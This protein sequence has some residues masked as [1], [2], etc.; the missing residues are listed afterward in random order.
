MASQTESPQANGCSWEKV[1]RE[2]HSR[3]LAQQQAWGDVDD[4]DLGRYLA[5][6]LSSAETSHLEDQLDA[7]PELR[8]LTD[9]VRDVLDGVG[10]VESAEEPAPVLRFE[11]PARNRH[12]VLTFLRRRASVLAAACL[13]IILGTAMPQAGYFSA[14]HSAS[15]GMASADLADRNGFFAQN[16]AMPEAEGAMPEQVLANLTMPEPA[17]TNSIRG[18]QSR[19]QGNL[20]QA[21]V[22]FAVAATE[23]R[24]SLGDESPAAQWTVRQLADVYQTALNSSPNDPTQ[25]P[26]MYSAD[27]AQLNPYL[28]TRPTPG[29]QG[30]HRGKGRAD[31][32]VAHSAKALREKI[33]K[34]PSRSVAQVL[35]N[36]IQVAK[37]DKERH[38]LLLALRHLGPAAADALPVLNERLLAS[39]DPVERREVLLVLSKLGPAAQPAMPMVA[40]LAGVSLPEATTVRFTACMAEALV[41][42]R[43][44]GKAAAEKALANEVFRKLA[45]KDGRVGVADRVGCFSVRGVQHGT[46]LLRDMARC[47]TA[48][49]LIETTSAKEADAKR[50]QKLT[51]SPRGVYV[52]V[53]P[54]VPDVEVRL[55]VDLQREGH[56]ETA[57]RACFLESCKTRTFDRAL[58]RASVIL[59][60]T[61][62]EKK[63]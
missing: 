39:T 36:A 48:E 33:A 44:G 22:E 29:S 47:G 37:T 58:E 54:E 4:L 7:H 6:D 31:N 11:K 63:D 53:I 55:G 23:C 14:P 25:Q 50:K 10:E 24:Q 18:L 20:D 52:L 46:D 43:S 32:T 38:N 1:A 41:Q 12:R 51:L 16:L 5:G 35:G 13:L 49:I 9:L 34:Q 60:R 19:Q 61:P 26:F 62:A 15:T 28:V 27:A 2:L 59:A 8:A 17:R 57:L 42:N 56:C 30:Y 45:G 21:K 3:K 40:Q